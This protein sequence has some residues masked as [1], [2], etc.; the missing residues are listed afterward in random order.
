MFEGLEQ[1]TVDTSHGA[2]VV[3]AGRGVIFVQRHRTTTA[4]TY[5]LPH[6]VRHAAIAEALEKLGC[7]QTVGVCSVGALKPTTPPGTVVVADDYFN[8]WGV[9][10]GFTDERA[11]IAPLLDPTLRARLMTLT[12]DAHKGVYVQTRGPRFETRAEVR[13][14]ATLG[15][16]VG[17]TG[18]DE[19]T[20]CQ[21]RGIAY[22]MLCMVDNWVRVLSPVFWFLFS[23]DS[24]SAGQ[25]CRPGL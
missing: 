9:R 2:V 24:P 3:H 18:A 20:H 25:R 6:E 7:Q 11:H 5:E 23:S 15:E 13:F 14:L 17:M 21:E 8:L 16:V 12:P 4:Q 22:A 10:S 1:R 19:A